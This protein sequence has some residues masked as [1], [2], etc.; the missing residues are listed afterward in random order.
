MHAFFDQQRFDN[1]SDFSGRH[2]TVSSFFNHFD[3]GSAQGQKSI[4]PFST[5]K[6]NARRREEEEEEAGRQGSQTE[7]P[8]HPFLPPVLLPSM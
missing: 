1:H 7:R 4:F 8:F 6:S 5:R 3:H 2:Y